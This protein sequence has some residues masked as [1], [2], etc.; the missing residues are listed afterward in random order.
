MP[1]P[2]MQRDRLARYAMVVEKNPGWSVLGR[3]AKL[4]M[5]RVAQQLAER[6]FGVVFADEDAALRGVR[7]S[8]D[9]SVVE[10]TEENGGREL[11]DCRQ[12]AR[13]TKDLEDARVAGSGD[14][15]IKQAELQR[16]TASDGV[17]GPRI[18]QPLA[19][20]TGRR[21]ASGPFSKVEGSQG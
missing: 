19:Q 14:G 10:L 20:G 11:G 2:N 12:D 21:T 15:P 6:L 8:R 3:A 5:G 13:T 17:A 9:W 1:V 4:E 7:F 18:S 16:R